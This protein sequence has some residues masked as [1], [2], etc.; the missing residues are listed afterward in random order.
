MNR[1]TDD[2]DQQPGE[3]DTGHRLAHH[4]CPLCEAGC[5]VEVA[6]DGD[7]VV[8]IRG[9]R[10][11]VSSHGFLCPKGAALKDLHHD[12]DR[13][14]RPL[15]KRNGVFEEVSFD[16]AFAEIERRLVPLRAEH[17]DDACGLVIGNPAVH[18]TGTVLY[19]LDLAAALGSP[20]VFSSA[21]LDQ[22]P[23]HL[24]AGRLFGD[25]YSVPVPDID[26]TE[27][28][29]LIGSNPMV[30]NGSM[31]TVP[32]F[33]RRA[34][35]LRERGGR[36]IVIDPRRTETAER[37]DHHVA[38]WPGTDVFLLA[39]VVR[40]LLAEGLVDLGRLE[41]FVTGLDAVAAATAPFTIELAAQRCGLDAGTISWLARTIA[42]APSASIHGRLGTCVQPYGT[43]VSWLVDVIHVLT[44]NLDRPGGAMFATPPAFA[45]NTQGPPGSGA[46]I[47]TGRYASKVSGAPE[48]M[49]QLPMACLAEEIESTDPDRLRALI[50]LA[51]NPA[52]SAPDSDRTTAALERLDLLVCLDVHLNETTRH[53]DVIIPARS[54]FAESHFDVFFS[55]YATRNTARFHRAVIAPSSVAADRHDADD[56]VPAD[57][58]SMVRLIAIVMGRGAD[59]SPDDVDEMLLRSMLGP[60]P[61]DAVDGI[62]AATAGRRGADRRL[63]LA[64]RSGPFGDQ[65]GAVPDGLSLARLEDSP[66][67]IDL[68]PLVA[69]LPDALRTVSG[70][71]E[72]A[73]DDLLGELTRAANE[74]EDRSGSDAADGSRRPFVL[75]GRRQLRSNNSWMHNVAGLMRGRPR[76]TLQIHPDDAS[77]LDLDDGGLARV[78][79]LTGRS[80]DVPV[81]HHDAMRPGV[82]S[83]PHGWGH[84]QPGTRLAIANGQPGQSLNSLTDADDREHLTGTAV[85][86]GIDVRIE[87]SPTGAP[88]AG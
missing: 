45:A 33:P 70:T 8:R 50:T 65:F 51:A 37:A 69:R 48:V 73:H 24:A 17:G 14:R 20:N 6:L 61:A 62:L 82:V 47:V 66:D 74:L 28:L 41:P 88:D 52:L 13:L 77:A 63:D 71:I 4:A 84:G 36:M 18:R 60:M 39:A 40:T 23:K 86:S 64:I 79:S 59:A 75:I 21:S 81:E 3:A 22:M 42:A 16:E 25:F 49:G 58:E 83:L 2:T 35:A 31:W 11:D 87:R 78:T 12:P 85:L 68:G 32:D 1:P 72:L 56:P 19:A 38:P 29:V 57:W 54:P 27:L 34:A 46:G 44:G 15:V 76:F 9:N 5:G 30:S 26:R 80:I 55:Q 67:G 10:G 53:A 43:A 7:R